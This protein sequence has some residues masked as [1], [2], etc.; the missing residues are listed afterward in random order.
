M[1]ENEKTKMLTKGLK[2]KE[3]KVNVA[4]LKGK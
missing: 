3:F 1:I 2:I 4:I